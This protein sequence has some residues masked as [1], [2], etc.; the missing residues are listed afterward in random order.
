MLTVFMLGH[1]LN[2]YKWNSTDAAVTFQLE[3]PQYLL[4]K[5]SENRDL[6]LSK[7]FS[8]HKSSVVM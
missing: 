6:L 1:Q 7:I 2:A 8:S 3:R 4:L 5:I